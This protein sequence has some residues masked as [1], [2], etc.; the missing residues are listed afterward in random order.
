M[1]WSLLINEKV[2]ETNKVLRK[3]VLDYYNNRIT[4]IYLYTAPEAQLS[5]IAGWWHDVCMW[6]KPYILDSEVADA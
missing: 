4:D 2:T 3:E 6:L 5:A 1:W